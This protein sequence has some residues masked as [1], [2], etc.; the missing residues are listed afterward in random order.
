MFQLGIRGSKMFQ[1]ESRGSIGEATECLCGASEKHGLMFS[2]G[3]HG[4]WGSR[5]FTKDLMNVL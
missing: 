5:T 2:W 4:N 1:R 3:S